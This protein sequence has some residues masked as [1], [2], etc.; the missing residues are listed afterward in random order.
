MKVRNKLKNLDAEFFKDKNILIDRYRITSLNLRK[1][2]IYEKFMTNRI[3]NLN[4]YLSPQF[5]NSSEIFEFYSNFEENQ[6]IKFLSSLLITKKYDNVFE[7]IDKDQ[8]TIDYLSKSECVI[9][10]IIENFEKEKKN[11]NFC[12]IVSNIFINSK[13]AYQKIVNE[14]NTIIKSING[15]LNDLFS[16]FI[17]DNTS[18]EIYYFLF[19]TFAFI[20]H[21]DI[22]ALFFHEHLLKKCIEYISKN[23]DINENILQVFDIILIFSNCES[24]YNFFIQ[25]LNIITNNIYNNESLLLIQYEILSNLS[26][27]SD[28]SSD[29]QRLIVFFTKCIFEKINSFTYS[30]NEI[31]SIFKALTNITSSTLLISS[32]LN[33][34]QKFLETVLKIPFEYSISTIFNILSQNK[35]TFSYCVKEKIHIKLLSFLK[36]HFEDSQNIIS[37]CLEV[38]D[39][40]ISY[41][42]EMRIQTNYIKI[43][44]ENMGID[45]VLERIYQATKN[46]TAK[47]ILEK[48][49]NWGKDEILRMITT[50]L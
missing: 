4:I 21:M 47:Y 48:Y 23:K 16:N 13:T 12:L 2:K 45:I 15:V 19:F 22:E 30:K 7:L 25:N 29:L 40:I 5:Q 38:I 3:K 1:K 32:L 10:Y 44:L 41:G 43:D 8:N 28:S 39:M 50:I 17:A 34:N 9:Q 46:E 18:D 14:N 26:L 36:Q 33:T 37:T 11:L 27:H 6:K 42:D 20:F 35:G 49:W 24:L 31:N